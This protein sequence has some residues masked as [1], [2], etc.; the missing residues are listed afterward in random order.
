MTEWKLLGKTGASLEGTCVS[1]TNHIVASREGYT[2]AQAVSLATE[3]RLLSL[4]FLAKI[5]LLFVYYMSVSQGENPDPND[6]SVSLTAAVSAGVAFALS[7]VYN[8]GLHRI[9]FEYFGAEGSYASR[10]RIW[11]AIVGLLH[12][13]VAGAILGEVLAIEFQR[14]S[15]VVLRYDIWE[16]GDTTKIVEGIRTLATQNFGFIVPTFSLVSGAQHLLT[17]VI[18]TKERFVDQGC[19]WVWRTIDYSISATLIFIVNTFVF[20]RFA[21]IAELLGAAA[22]MI[23]IMWLGYGAETIWYLGRSEPLSRMISYTLFIAG[24]ISFVLIW[25]PVFWRLAVSVEDSADV[26]SLV[27]IFC[28]FIFSSFALFPA[29]ILPKLLTDP[30]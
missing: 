14:S 21:S 28:A 11:N 22:S 26:P 7:L 27:F 16:S 30:R 29:V 10:F 23:A 8:L 1:L 17:A 13:G 18:F 2:M 12:L 4:S 15:F 24:I 25:I 20:S 6:V 9:S 19:S 5:P 3:F